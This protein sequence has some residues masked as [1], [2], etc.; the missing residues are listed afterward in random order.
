[1]DLELRDQTGAR[2]MSNPIA[3]ASAGGLVPIYQSAEE[4]LQ[5]AKAR[6]AELLEQAAG[7]PEVRKATLVWQAALRAATD[8]TS[9]AK[10]DQAA[11]AA[12]TEAAEAAIPDIALARKAIEA[13]EGLKAETL[14]RI[15]ALVPGPRAKS[16]SIDDGDVRI[17]WKKS[18]ESTVTPPPD[19]DIA[20]DQLDRIIDGAFGDFRLA[21][22]DEAYEAVKSS[23]I[24]A[25]VQFGAWPAPVKRLSETPGVLITL[26]H[27]GG[28]A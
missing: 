21:V 27:E 24:D 20:R 5:K 10:A 16:T 14:A 18:R 8:A 28:P 9:Q 13:A 6:L 11:L 23:L 2:P 26:R 25:M 15:D 3:H 12:A 19:S 1:M 7:T 17:T 22:S 4:T